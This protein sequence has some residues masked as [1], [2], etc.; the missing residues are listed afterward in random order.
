MAAVGIRAVEVGEWRRAQ[1]R[2]RAERCEED[3]GADGGG[4]RGAGTFEGGRRR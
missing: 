2:C 4:R 1:I 3:S